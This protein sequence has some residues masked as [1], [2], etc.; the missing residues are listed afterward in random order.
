[1]LIAS[2]GCPLLVKSSEVTT[3]CAEIDLHNL[4]QGS[5]KGPASARGQPV[6]L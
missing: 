1:M 6:L 3:Y 5:P 4:G 2:P